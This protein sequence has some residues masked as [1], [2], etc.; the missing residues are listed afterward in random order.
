MHRRPHRA[1]HFAGRILA[2]HARHRL[3]VGVRILVV[4]DEIIVNAYPVHLPPAPHLPLPHHRNIVLALAG[5][6]AGVA[7]DA[8]V[9][10]DHHAPGVG[11]GL[12][13]VGMFVR[14]VE[15]EAALGRFKL[16]LRE[17]RIHLIL[18]QRGRAQDA[19]LLLFLIAAVVEVNVPVHVHR[20][21]VVLLSRLADLQPIRDVLRG[22]RPQQIS[23]IPVPIAGAAC[24]VAPVSQVQGDTIFRPA[25]HDPR[26]RF[27]FPAVQVEFNYFGA[28]GTSLQA[29][30][31]RRAQPHQHGVVPGDHADGRGQL[32]QPAV[33]G[34]ASI[35]N[36]WIR[37]EN[38]L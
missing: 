17:P 14:L 7:A 31:F 32:L 22:C 30:L 38:N 3:E 19:A 34:E 35:M 16:R 5:H 15:R 10:I 2:L 6:H 27:Q 37:P 21:H 23:V 29:Q 8:R 11:R 33:V 9:Q 36:F 24:L 26:H 4:T 1:N 20:R 28:I 18:V 12:F 25:R 13:V